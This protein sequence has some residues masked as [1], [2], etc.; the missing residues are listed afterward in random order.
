[1]KIRIGLRNSKNNDGLTHNKRK[2][3]ETDTEM[4]SRIRTVV[5]I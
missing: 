1:M 2:I 5:Y 4:I 3:E